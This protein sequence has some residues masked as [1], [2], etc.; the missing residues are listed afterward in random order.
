MK[1]TALRRRLRPDVRELDELART[2]C[3]IRAGAALVTDEGR[4]QWWGHCL[5][6]GK[7]AWLSWCHCLTR[8][9]HSTRWDP[10]G[11]FAWCRGC[12]R[13]LD[14]HWH[15]K[16][17]WVQERIGAERFEALMLRARARTRPDRAAILVALKEKR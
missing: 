11:S 6:C 4:R 17:E 5:Y 15:L 12:H 16:A 7:L 13:M 8:A 2:A 9:S 14:Q 1:R 10:D 3:M